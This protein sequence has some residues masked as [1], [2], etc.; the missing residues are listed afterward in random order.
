MLQS[1]NPSNFRRS[2]QLSLVTL[3]GLVM[4]GFLVEPRIERQDSPAGEAEPSQ[5]NMKVSGD[6]GM[7]WYHWYHTV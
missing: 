2:S 3:N 1:G 7:C 6:V 5:S 4:V